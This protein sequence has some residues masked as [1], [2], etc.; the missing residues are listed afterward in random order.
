MVPTLLLLYATNIAL[1]N[2]QHATHWF[3]VSERNIQ[4]NDLALQ[5]QNGHGAIP[6]GRKGEGGKRYKSNTTSVTYLCV[7]C[8]HCGKSILL[9]AILLVMYF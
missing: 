1:N 8:G 4:K 3:S 2:I 9:F 7:V 6:K 5:E